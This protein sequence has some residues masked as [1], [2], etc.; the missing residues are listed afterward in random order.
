MKRLLLLRH[1]KAVPGTTKQGDHARPLN[2]RGR[3]DAPRMGAEMQHKGYFPDVVLCST[4]KRTVE[5]WRHVAPE[6]G[7]KLDAQLLDS[8]YLASWKAIANA[9]RALD[10]PAKV[11]LFI[12]H[13]PGLEECARALARKP[14][15]DDESDRL[16][17]LSDKFPTAAL[18]VLDF[19]V[20]A[21]KEIGSGMG[22]LY[23]FIRPRE[24]TGG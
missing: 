9:A 11:A 8:L 2:D 15:S 14:Q 10:E 13:N 4:S 5:T 20:D 16:A 22:E 6:L 18:A 7:G 19:D 23:D 24:L 1:A 17:L 21:W 12:G 3:H